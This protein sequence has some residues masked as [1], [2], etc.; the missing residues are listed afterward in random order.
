M[1]SDVAVVV[2]MA[3]AMVIAKPLIDAGAQVS[4]HDFRLLGRELLGSISVGTSVGLFL[5]AYLRIYGGHLVLLLLALGFGLTEL[6]HYVHVD[7]LLS[8]LV[9]GFVVQ[10][11]SAQGETLVRAVERF[12]SIVFVV[13]FATAGAH[14]DLGLLFESWP[15]ALALCAVRALSTLATAQVTSRLTGDPQSLRRWGW[16]SLVSQAGL[17]LGLSLVVERSFPALGT[18]FR[19]LVVVTVALNEIVGPVLFKL[20]LEKAGEAQSVP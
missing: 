18:S 19:S 2:M 12:S 17:T 5:A 14:L 11:L 7:P 6:M 13:F 20:G 3:A 8:F 10:N 16:T 15:V 4:L 9:A 1:A